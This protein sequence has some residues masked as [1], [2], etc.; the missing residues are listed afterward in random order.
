MFDEPVSCTSV[1]T[2]YSS[3]VLL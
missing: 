1:S 2:I 3:W